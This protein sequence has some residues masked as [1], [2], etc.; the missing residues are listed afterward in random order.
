[1]PNGHHSSSSRRAALLVMSSLLGIAGCTGGQ[2][3]ELRQSL[4]PVSDVQPLQIASVTPA[5]P[6]RP[7]IEPVADIQI[8][9][10]QS[11]WCAKLKESSAAEAI[12]L[13]SPTLTGSLDDSGNATLGLSVSY[14]SF[15]K[16]KFAEQ[17]AEA[18]CRKYL[19]ET[20]LQKLVFV[21][22]QNLT[23]AGYRA[24]YNTIHAQNSKLKKLRK[25]IAAAM[26]AGTV[27]RE[28][29]TALNLS[30]D[31]Y[32]A[33]GQAA[34]S[35]ADR[36]ISERLLVPKGA[37]ILSRELL[38]AEADLDTIDSKVRTANAMDVTARL[39]WGDDLSS[40]GLNVSD[41]SFSGK[42]S[43]T[44]QL[45]ALAPQRFQHERRASEL[46]RQAIKSEEGGAIW[47]IGVLRR[48][49][50]RAISGLIGSQA[51]FD[52]AIK[53]AEHLQDVLI[54]APQPEFDGARLGAEFE[55]LKLHA[56]RA[57]VAGSIAEI[58]TNLNRLK[59]G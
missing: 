30:I 13:R 15:A 12:I 58:N 9:A 17:Q 37:D 54:S 4:A 22:P 27:D 21:S 33:E 53:E 28:K 56:E 3:L 34:K 10:T 23:A 55:V 19:A 57:S 32:L 11:S 59:N 51:K 39:G 5:F 42:V 18:R 47:Q 6:L 50:E 52:Q 29:A 38:E 49:H 16:A 14:S 2:L 26:I 48:I 8:A 25:D 31:R 46:A 36:R 45:G 43:F 20:G 41:Q 35:Q 44:M 7:R 24:K 1:M 40:D